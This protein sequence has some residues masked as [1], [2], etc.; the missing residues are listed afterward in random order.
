MI[1]ARRAPPRAAEAG[2][3]GHAAHCPDNL[4]L[5]QTFDYAARSTIPSPHA[6]LT[7]C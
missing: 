3:P 4:S 1:I 7:A 5:I 2:A 6:D